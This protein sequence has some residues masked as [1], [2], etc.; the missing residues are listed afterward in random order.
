MKT[1]FW[2]K[3][4]WYATYLLTAIGLSP[5]GRSTVHIYTQIIHRMIQNKQYVHRTTQQFWKSAGHALSW[6]VIPWHL[7]YNRGKCTEKPQSGFI[8]ILLLTLNCWQC[9]FT[10]YTAV[11]SYLLTVN[12]CRQHFMFGYYNG[13]STFFSPTNETF[14]S[15][16]C[17]RSME[18]KRMKRNEM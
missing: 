13:T 17:E 1:K 6:L 9:L 14:I 12:S 8:C 2:K 15:I 18:N 10:Q 5:G 4:I 11:T 16:S 3:L 7:P